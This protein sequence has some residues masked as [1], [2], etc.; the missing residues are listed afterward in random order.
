MF[1]SKPDGFHFLIEFFGCDDA[2]IND[3]H[4]WKKTLNKSIEG[5]TMEALHDFFFEFDPQGITGYVLLSSSHISIHTWP[6]NG[7][8]V[9]DVFTCSSEEETTSVV[10]F[11]KDHIIHA[12][13]EMKKVQRGYRVA[14]KGGAIMERQGCSF[15]QYRMA[16]PVF[17]TGELMYVNVVQDI[18]EIE[19]ALQKIMIVDTKEF[20]KCLLID[21]MLQSAAKDHYLYDRELI[22]K[23]RPSDQN[24]L[25]LGG[26]DGYVAGR[27]IAENPA[28]NVHVEVVDLDVE[29]VRTC[30][31]YLG[32]DIFCH[33]KVRLHIADAI[34]FLKTT[35]KKYDG[36]IFDLTDMPIGRKEAE[37]LTLFYEEACELA[38]N[39]MSDGGWLAIQV[40]ASTVTEGYI[41]T[42]SI[43]RDVLHKKIWASVEQSDLYIPS[44]GS[45]CIFLFAQ[46]K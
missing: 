45:N 34:H 37:K 6:E 1:N 36:I 15:E 27:I 18:V 38:Y 46:K 41:D 29:V 4:F 32:Q 35:D 33:E 42:V 10:Q 2:Q 23:L 22:K 7:Y 39:K 16:I 31:R 9:C 11:L 43:V 30:E 26:G 44:F 8:V 21:G 17:S 40:G 25:V 19:T 13:V 24:V 14:R 12:R 5:T 20:G 28:S 3:V